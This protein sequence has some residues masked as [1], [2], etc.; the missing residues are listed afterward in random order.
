LCHS[1]PC[2]FMVSC[3]SKE[4][5][6]DETAFGLETTERAWRMGHALRVLCSRRGGGRPRLA[7]SVAVVA[8]G[9]GNVW[10]TRVAGC[11]VARSQSRTTNPTIQPGRHPAGC[12]LCDCSCQRWTV[13][14]CLQALLVVAPGAPGCR[15]SGH[16]WAAGDGI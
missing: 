14:C 12:I 2:F 8:G 9:Y 4:T 13:D 16:Q 3:L 7:S 10:R 5:G 15:T 11:V 6:F 1:G